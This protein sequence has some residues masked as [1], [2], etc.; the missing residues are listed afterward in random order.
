MSL[1][2]MRL[3]L[4]GKPK[5]AGRTTSQA[6]DAAGDVEHAERGDEGG[7]AEA[8]RERAVDQAAQ[9][10]AEEREDG[11]RPRIE[12]QLLH[13]EGGGRAR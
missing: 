7:Q 9:H 3:K 1:R 12:A 4:S 6:R 10:A 2:P 11:R 8:D 5:A 13:R